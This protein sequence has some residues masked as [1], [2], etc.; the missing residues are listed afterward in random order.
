[1]FKIHNAN[2][3]DTEV[4][5]YLPGKASETITLGEALI[6]KATGLEKCPEAERPQYICRGE[7]NQD[8]MYPVGAVMESTRYEAPY[9][10]KPTVGTKVTLHTD[11][12]QVT[13]TTTGGV[14]FVESV[15]EAKGTAIGRFDWST[16]D[17]AGGP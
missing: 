9:Q 1:M 11:A 5:M 15:D 2:V 6:Y 3:G 16:K 14:F 10:A 7:K 8:D 17:A 4:L 12:L 13:A